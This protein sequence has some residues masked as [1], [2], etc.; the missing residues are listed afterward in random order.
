MT[1]LERGQLW[2][3]RIHALIGAAILLVIAAVADAILRDEIAAPFG[4]VL[5]PVLLILLYPVFI[6][7][8]RQ[9]RAW[10]Y[11]KDER[12]LHLGHG[13]WTQMQ[14]IVPLR[15]VQHIDV[16]QGPIERAF[17]VCRLILHTAGTMHSRVTL[18]G[19]SRETAETM[20]ED[21]RAHIR[22]DLA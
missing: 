9:F 1:P 10:G 2:V 12:D 8:G 7:P 16:S 20:R 15:R 3:M 4:S 19:L 11:R 13:V 21:I 18:P 5:A 14:T 22:Q 6:G 17:G